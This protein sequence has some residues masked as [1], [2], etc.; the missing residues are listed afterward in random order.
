MKLLAL[1]VLVML[2]AACDVTEQLTC[3]FFRFSYTIDEEIPEEA[4]IPDFRFVAY[5]NGEQVGSAGI[6]LSEG[7]HT[8]TVNFDRT[9]PDGTSI[10]MLIV[11]EEEG[12]EEIFTAP[13][14]GDDLDVFIPCLVGDGRLNAL[15]CG[16]PI[17]VYCEGEGIDVYAIDPE[18]G[19]GRLLLRLSAEE[20]EAIGIPEGENVTLA[21]QDGVLLSRLTD[22]K[23]QLNATYP[24]GKPYIITW[25]ACPATEIETLAW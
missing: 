10:T 22:G 24:D 15:H 19:D 25:D 4:E 23:F 12:S 14:N 9:Y 11:I 18:S 5:V 1:L 6:P 20:I 13:C 21:E 3:S 2:V 16:A 17:S 7:A 8:V